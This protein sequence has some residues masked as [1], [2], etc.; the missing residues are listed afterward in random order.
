MQKLCIVIPAYNEERRIGETLKVYSDY[1]EN[2]VK[3]GDMD[4][5]ILI[6]INN[7]SD[8]TEDV[9][10]LFQKR[11]ANIK[12]LNFRQGG[13]GFAVRKG[14]ED[15]LKRKN[16]L[17]GFVDADLATPPKAFNELIKNIRDY[18]GAIA[19]RWHPSS[20]IK[21]RQTLLRKITSKGFNFL[22]KSILFLNLSDT[23]CGAKL[24]TRK[25]VESIVGDINL[26]EWAFD[27]DFL[28]IL[29]NKGFKVIET[30]TI[31][32]DK[33]GSKIDLFFTPMQ[34]FLSILRIRLLSSPFD[35]I[36]RAYDKMPLAIK[37]LNRMLK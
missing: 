10:K 6:V 5:E 3:S 27:V 15:A 9:V 31:W 33:K 26:T 20:I 17:I 34:M 1:F 2:V 24:F 19:S 18:D 7:T 36:I 25:A 23:Q 37:L 29:K 11:N 4:Y 30:P 8:K 13:K 28:Y 22:V 35:F 16:D 14:F 21:T 32:E 12:Y